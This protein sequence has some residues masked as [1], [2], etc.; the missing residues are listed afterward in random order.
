MLHAIAKPDLMFHIEKSF[1]VESEHKWSLWRN[2]TPE[3]QQHFLRQAEQILRAIQENSSTVEFF[4]PEKVIL[5]DS[6]AKTFREESIPKRYRHQLLHQRVTQRKKSSLSRVLQ[7][8]C[9]LQNSSH[10]SISLSASILRYWV[11]HLWLN[12][13]PQGESLPVNS[14]KYDRPSDQN[15]V[16]QPDRYFPQWMLIDADGQPLFS[17][18]SEAKTRIQSIEETL[19]SL[20]SMI[21]FD[22]AIVEEKAFRSRYTGL[23]TQWIEQGRAYSEYLTKQIVAEI[24]HRNSQ[25]TLNRGLTI[26]LPYLNDQLLEIEFLEIE[27]VPAGRIAFEAVFLLQAIHRTEQRL[28]ENIKFSP[29]TRQHILAELKILETSFSDCAPYL[30][31]GGRSPYYHWI[32]LPPNQE[33]KKILPE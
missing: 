22:P 17:S 15:E 19:Q 16:D 25:H 4:L 12:Q 24:R 20:L 23:I 29:T 10:L 28:S 7:H 1:Y 6:V 3:V 13:I 11:A 9:D 30:P 26:R 33:I 8:L 31:V 32:N 2:Q 5:S 18:I 27:V 14:D 21:A